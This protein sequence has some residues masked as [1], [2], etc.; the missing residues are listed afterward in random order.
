MTEPEGGSE[1]I[2][3]P[4]REIEFRGRKIWVTLPK[5]EQIL[6]WQRTVKQL[7]DPDIKDWGAEQV[8]VALER[9]RKIIDSVILNKADKT[10]IDDE[11]L[12]GNFGIREAA[13]IIQTAME[14]FAA[15]ANRA[16]R[17]AAAKTPAKKAARKKA[18]AS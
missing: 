2:T 1:P 8:L 13:S 3:V 15:D 6:V 17:R 14:A 9:S 18:S 5:P 16:D 10:W 7:Q 11:M 12:E 4:E